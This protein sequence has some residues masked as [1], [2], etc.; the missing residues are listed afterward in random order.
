[1]LTDREGERD[2][3]GEE[4]EGRGGRIGAH[5]PSTNPGYAHESCQNYNWT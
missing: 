2:G 4:G 5:H 3:N 1:M